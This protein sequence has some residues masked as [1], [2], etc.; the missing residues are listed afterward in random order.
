VLRAADRG[1]RPHGF[2][3]LGSLSWRTLKITFVDGGRNG[4]PGYEEDPME[5]FVLRENVI[6]FKRQLANAKD[7]GHRKLLLKL[8]AEEERHQPGKET[9]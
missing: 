7:D 9:K 8:L 3:I 6:I 2:Y 4:E 5:D 1:I